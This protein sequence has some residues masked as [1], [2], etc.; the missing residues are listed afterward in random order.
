[1][2]DLK[3]NEKIANYF[4]IIK[5]KIIKRQEIGNE[6]YEELYKEKIINYMIKYIQLN[7]IIMILKYS[8]KQMNSVGLN[9]NH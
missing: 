1:M 6:Q 3:I 9:F 8:K 4:Q 7:L 2:K 5:E